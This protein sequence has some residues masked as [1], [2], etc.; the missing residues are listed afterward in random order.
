MPIKKKPSN[1]YTKKVFYNILNSKLFE[2]N[3]KTIIT[4]RYSNNNRELK[5]KK[6]FKNNIIK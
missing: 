5:D 3:K 1:N 6:I 4:D 2:E